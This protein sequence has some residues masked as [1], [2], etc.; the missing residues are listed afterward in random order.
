MKLRRLH[1]KNYIAAV[2]M[3]VLATLF[4]RYRSEQLRLSRAV[5]KDDY[6]RIAMETQDSK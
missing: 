1:I 3:K 2:M 6:I 5:N 4:E